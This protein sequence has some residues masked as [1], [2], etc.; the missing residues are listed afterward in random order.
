MDEKV[1]AIRVLI[2]AHKY[3]QAADAL[4][5][6]CQTDKALFRDTVISGWFVHTMGTYFYTY[7]CNVWTRP[8]E[9]VNG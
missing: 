2:H 8:G 5:A 4:Y 6:L 1:E 7:V 3:G 9:G